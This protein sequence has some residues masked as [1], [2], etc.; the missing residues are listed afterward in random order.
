MKVFYSN[1]AVFIVLA[2]F[3]NVIKKILLHRI[4]CKS[5]LATAVTI[6]DNT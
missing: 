3:N 1:F 6:T 4:Y 2:Y 5:V